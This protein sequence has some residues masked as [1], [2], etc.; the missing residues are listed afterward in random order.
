MIEQEDQERHAKSPVRQ[1]STATAK[2]PFLQRGQGKAGGVGL[3]T[4]N[5][6][7]PLKPSNKKDDRKSDYSL[8]K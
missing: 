3:Q 4:S 2:R 7:T 6:K 5:S 1:N 8:T